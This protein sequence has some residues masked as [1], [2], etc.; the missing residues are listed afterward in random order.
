VVLYIVIGF[1]AA[2]IL[3]LL[4]F[5]SRNIPVNPI[6]NWGDL[7]K[8]LS[9]QLAVL[10]GTLGSMIPLAE[11][12][13]TSLPELQSIQSLH[14]LTSS[15]GYQTFVALLAF[16]IPIARA[17]KQG[18]L[19]QPTTDTQAPAQKQQ[20]GYARPA[21]L[22][23]VAAASLLLFGCQTLGLNSTQ[24]VDQ[25]LL[26]AESTA[27]TALSVATDLLVQRKITLAQDQAV[28][29]S[30]DIVI[31]LAHTGHAAFAAGN[32]SASQ[33][34][35]DAMRGDLQTLQIFLAAHPAGGS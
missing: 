19:A 31:A 12:L 2:V 5:R 23:L 15:A 10:T 9:V 33:T 14:A 20:G 34:Q 4:A 26:E 11:Q 28:R 18:K 21:L 13:Q 25:D 35:L 32:T 1:L 22:A 30:H 3:A 8:M 7:H 6:S 27:T 29:R 16:C 17:W 24:T